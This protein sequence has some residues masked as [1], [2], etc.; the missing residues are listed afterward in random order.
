M[1]ENERRYEQKQ[2]GD[3]RRE[4]ESVDSH[5]FAPVSLEIVADAMRCRAPGTAA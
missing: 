4:A 1:T 5:S 2:L 3:Q